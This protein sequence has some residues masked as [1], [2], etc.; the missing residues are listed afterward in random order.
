MAPNPFQ[1]RQLRCTI[2]VIPERIHIISYTATYTH[3]DLWKIY[4]ENQ[5]LAIY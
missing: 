3:K 5:I 1:P 2:G 4:E